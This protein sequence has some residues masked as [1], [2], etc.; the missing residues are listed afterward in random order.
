MAALGWKNNERIEF[1]CGGSIISERFILTAAHCITGTRQNLPS[2]VRVGDSNLQALHMDDG[3]AK[4]DPKISSIKDFA[5]QWLIKHPSYSSKTKENDIGLIKV[6]KEIEFNNF[7]LPACLQQNNNFDPRVKAVIIKRYANLVLKLTEL[8]SQ[9]GWGR[10]HY[11]GDTSNILLEGNLT[12]IKN[13]D[14]F[15]KLG[16]ELELIEIYQSQICAENIDGTDTCQ[17]GER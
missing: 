17:G 4:I 12:I 3:I 11:F 6:S 15:E 9:T 2:V 14:C 16:E 1:K 7:V 5:I 8:I 10:T 13:D